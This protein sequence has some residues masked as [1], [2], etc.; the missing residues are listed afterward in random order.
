MM[1]GLTFIT[2]P[3]TFTATASPQ[4]RGKMTN[5]SFFKDEIH[6]IRA[7]TEDR[8]ATAEDEPL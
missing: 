4:D 5:R 3:T 8:P 6:V 7:T 2:F 1:F